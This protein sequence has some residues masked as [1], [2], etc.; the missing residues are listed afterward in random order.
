MK[1]L[2]ATISPGLVRA[3]ADQTVRNGW[4]KLHER[5]DSQE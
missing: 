4:K 2:V 1:G 5:L 3:A